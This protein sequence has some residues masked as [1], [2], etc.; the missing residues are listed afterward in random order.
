LPTSHVFH[1]RRIEDERLDQPLVAQGGHAVIA[2]IGR[3]NHS[4][5]NRPS[6]KTVK[7][8]WKS[9]FHSGSAL[10]LLLSVFQGCTQNVPTNMPKLYPCPLVITQGNHPLEGATIALYHQDASL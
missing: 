5:F 3:E 1:Y 4:I 10:L 7:H 9:I 8:L 6:D 2:E